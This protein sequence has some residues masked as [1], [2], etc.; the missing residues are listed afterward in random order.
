MTKQLPD[1]FYERIKPRLHKR[2]GRELRLT[3]L[4]S[5]SPALA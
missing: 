2:I 1:S 3:P 5:A 4:T